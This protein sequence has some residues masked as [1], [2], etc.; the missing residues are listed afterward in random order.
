[1]HS[2]CK[3]SVAS[4][5]SEDGPLPGSWVISRDSLKHRWGTES[6]WHLPGSML[7]DS[8]PLACTR[9]MR[10]GRQAG[11]CEHS[12]DRQVALHSCKGPHA[13]R[14]WLFPPLMCLSVMLLKGISLNC[15]CD[16]KL[17]GGIHPSCIRSQCGSPGP[18]DQHPLSESLGELS[19]NH[20]SSAPP[21]CH[22]GCQCRDGRQPNGGAS[23][24]AR[25]GSQ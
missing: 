24:S 3:P 21:V 8:S 13:R 25:Q 5:L 19:E 20:L 17:P 15:I 7:A 22:L 4:H 18:D 6:T 12:C 11:S 14:L 9:C 10:Q 23:G 16:V 1:M 2:L